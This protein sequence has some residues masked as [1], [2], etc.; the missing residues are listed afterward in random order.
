[1]ILWI[2]YIFSEMSFI[3]PFPRGNCVS[4]EAGNKDLGL[5]KKEIRIKYL[6]ND[7]NKMMP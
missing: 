7:A 5:K 2:F 4:T 3:C 1:M 6:N